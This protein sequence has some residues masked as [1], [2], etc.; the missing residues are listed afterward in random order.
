M[1]EFGG[2]WK[3]TK[4]TQPALKVSRVFRMFGD[5]LEEEEEKEEE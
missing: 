4:I 1:S 3:H 2:L 5:Y